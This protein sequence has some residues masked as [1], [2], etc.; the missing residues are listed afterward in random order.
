MKDGTPYHVQLCVESGTEHSSEMLKGRIAEAMQRLSGR[1]RW[2][3][4]AAPVTRLSE[5]QLDYLTALDNRFKVAW[6]AWVPRD[7]NELGIGLGR[8]VA[9]REDLA[10]AEFALTVVD[11]YQGQGVGEVLLRRLVR[12]ALENRIRELRGHVLA[13]NRAMLALSRHFDA[14]IQQGKAGGMLVTLRLD[15]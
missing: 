11:D 15:A 9:L 13:G 8:Y 12:S 1:S 6:C 7:G 5:Q 14:H 3:R 4:F 10:I 2:Q